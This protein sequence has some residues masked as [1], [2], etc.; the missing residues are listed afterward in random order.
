MKPEK[1][2]KACKMRYTGPQPCV[3]VPDSAHLAAESALLLGKLIHACPR[4]VLPYVPPILKALVS[5]LRAS[6]P[7][8]IAGPAPSGVGAAPKG[9]V[10][11]GAAHQCPTA[12]SCDR[13]CP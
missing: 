9:A 12:S 10:A 6:G 2:L 1:S 5:K 8:L 3:S 4:L 11:Q 13:L 7:A